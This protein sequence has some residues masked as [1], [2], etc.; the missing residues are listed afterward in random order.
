MT[1][2]LFRRASLF[3]CLALVAGLGSSGDARAD[4]PCAAVPDDPARLAC[5]DAAFGHPAAMPAGIALPAVS[6]AD[7]AA[8]ARRD[9]G[10]SEADKR[11]LDPERVGPTQPQSISGKVATVRKRPTGEW[12]TTLESGQVWEQAESETKAVIR[13]GDEVTV[14]KAALGSF[15]LISANRIP[16]RVR[17]IK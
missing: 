8:Q 16:M 12:V 2:P 10:L 13:I 9:F 4:H 17:R 5:Y 6:A 7:A 15:V 3:P 11:A 14:R 1:D